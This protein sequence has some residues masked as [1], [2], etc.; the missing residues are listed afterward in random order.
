MVDDV[1]GGGGG[2]GNGGSDID[3]AGDGAVV[4]QW[5]VKW[6]WRSRGFALPHCPPPPR[7][8]TGTEVEVVVAG[9]VAV[10]VVVVVVPVEV[11]VKAG[12]LA[13]EN[14]V[15]V[16]LHARRR[17]RHAPLGGERGSFWR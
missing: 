10:A 12:P 6:V 16:R 17:C 14:E 11:V 7:P 15:L 9:A 4:A 5:V 8:A 1:G 3:V 13:R 2:V